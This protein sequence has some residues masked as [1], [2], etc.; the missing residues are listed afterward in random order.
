[1]P[2]SLGLICG[3]DKKNFTSNTKL[4]L[5]ATTWWTPAKTKPMWSCPCNNTEFRHKPLNKTKKATWLGLRAQFTAEVVHCFSFSVFVM[6]GILRFCLLWPP[7]HTLPPL[8]CYTVDSSALPSLGML[9]H[10][11]PRMASTL[12]PADTETSP[13][14]PCLSALSPFSQKSCSHASHPPISW[15]T[16]YFHVLGLLIHEQTSY[17]TSLCLHNQLK[18]ILGIDE[19]SRYKQLH[20]EFKNQKVG[21]TARLWHKHMGINDSREYCKW[22]RS[23]VWSWNRQPHTDLAGV[24]HA[25]STGQILM[26]ANTLRISQPGLLFS[27]W[28]AATQQT[29]WYSGM[30]PST[31]S[32]LESSVSGMPCH[33][34]SSP[35][36]ALLFEAVWDA[37]LHPHRNGKQVR[38]HRHCFMINKLDINEQAWITSLHI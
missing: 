34:C 2:K 13:S 31:S 30:L 7:W 26:S 3:T 11:Q 23:V 38:A 24:Q 8:G 32:Q 12:E 16:W 33:F 27:T 10:P 14:Q 4:F 9:G 29:W 22:G 18:Q 21:I 35:Q 28:W 19:N 17:N 20:M 6:C 5:K 15:L 25:S 37:F 36:T 1:M